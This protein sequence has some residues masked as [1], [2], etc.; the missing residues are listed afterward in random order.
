ME[1]RPFGLEM[2]PSVLI[3]VRFKVPANLMV[4]ILLDQGRDP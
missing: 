3:I 4:Q 2:I 1:I